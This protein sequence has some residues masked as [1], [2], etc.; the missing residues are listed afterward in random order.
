[1]KRKQKE[2]NGS[3][4]IHD[5]GKEGEGASHLTKFTTAWNVQIQKLK[6]VQ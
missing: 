3:K 2:R 1:M 6:E 4:S 5:A